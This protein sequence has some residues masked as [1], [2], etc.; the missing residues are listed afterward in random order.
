MK[1]G[2]RKPKVEIHEGPDFQVHGQVYAYTIIT[3]HHGTFFGF[4]VRERAAVEEDWLAK[5]ALA[6]KRL[7]KLDLETRRVDAAVSCEHGREFPSGD[8]GEGVRPIESSVV[9]PTADEVFRLTGIPELNG[10]GACS[11]LACEIRGILT[12][13]PGE[14]MEWLEEAGF[15]FVKPG[16]QERRPK[17][18]RRYKPS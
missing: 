17:R 6:S 7:A 14:A 2:T 9:A 18:G 16:E 11:V 1:N 15:Q 13:R 5:W 8:E 4:D 10:L 3:C 12:A